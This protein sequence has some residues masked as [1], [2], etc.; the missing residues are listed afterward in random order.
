MEAAQAGDTG[1][2]WVTARRQLQGKARR[3]R[4]W[5]S[6]EGNLYA[7]LLLIEPAPPQ[8]IGQLPLVAS[9][10]LHRAVVTAMPEVGPRLLIKWPNDLLLD[11]KKLSGMLLE[12]ATFGGK[13]ADLI[14]CG[15]NCAHHPAQAM[16]PSTSL[17]ESVAPLEPETLFLHVARQMD[18]ALQLWNAG[19]GFR[20]IRESWLA[21]C[22]GL[23]QPITARFPDHEITG[24]FEDIDADGHLVL[25]KPQGVQRISAA[26]IFFGESDQ[27]R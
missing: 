1:Q 20:D 4:G 11:G 27:V 10:A 12:A 18:E 17:A 21:R 5:V 16:Y 22:A 2:L 25:R 6:E 23:G 24:T 7:S 3:G 13:Q 26:D 14:G 8:T 19:A 15:I 9:V